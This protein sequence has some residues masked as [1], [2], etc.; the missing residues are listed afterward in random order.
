MYP[1][2]VLLLVSLVGLLAACTQPGVA[3]GPTPTPS[4]APTPG[5]TPGQ[6]EPYSVTGVAVDTQGRPIA[7]A[8]VWINP[9]LTFGEVVETSTDSSGRYLVTGLWT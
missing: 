3:P 2:R 6:P 5:P 1:K 4:P 9:A 7:G 8:K